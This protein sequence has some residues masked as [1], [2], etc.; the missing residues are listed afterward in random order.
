[1]KK[2]LPFLLFALMIALFTGCP[3]VDD[4]YSVRDR[5]EAFIDDANDESWSD[6]KQHTDPDAADYNTANATFWENALANF[7]PLEDLA[8]SGQTAT[9]TGAGDVTFY[10]FLNADSDDNNLINHIE[11]GSTMVFR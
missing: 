3:M 1:M 5:M 4:A 7:I 9:C 10:F 8:V 11:R 6:L 2:L